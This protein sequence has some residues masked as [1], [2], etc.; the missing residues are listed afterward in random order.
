MSFSSGRTKLWTLYTVVH[1]VGSHNFHILIY[2]Y[3]HLFK[4]FLQGVLATKT[5]L[6]KACL[7]F[8]TT[9]SPCGFPTSKGSQGGFRG[10]CIKDCLTLLSKQQ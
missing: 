3:H 1:R 5:S 7:W 2:N 10:V 8:T 9:V 4:I 6:I